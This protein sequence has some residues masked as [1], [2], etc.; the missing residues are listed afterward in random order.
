MSNYETIPNDFRSFKQKKQLNDYNNLCKSNI[1]KEEE[2][3]YINILIDKF[4]KM[5]IN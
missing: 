2:Q 5:V 3:G 4:K 1:S